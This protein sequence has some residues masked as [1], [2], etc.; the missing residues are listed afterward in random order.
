MV[1]KF[2]Q[3]IAYARSLKQQHKKAIEGYKAS[4]ELLEYIDKIYQKEYSSKDD[5]FEM[6]RQYRELNETIEYKV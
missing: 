6:I 4:V 3:L 2:F 5:F 1:K